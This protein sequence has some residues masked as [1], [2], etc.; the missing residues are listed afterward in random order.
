MLVL[1]SEGME[2]RL[3]DTCGF[4]NVNFSDRDILVALATVPDSG[5]PYFL[6]V[7]MV[8][9]TCGSLSHENPPTCAHM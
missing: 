7:L 8:E 5:G 3:Q 1:R 4:E 6:M 2:M 9:V